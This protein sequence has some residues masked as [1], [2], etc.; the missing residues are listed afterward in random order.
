[1]KLKEIK[2][3]FKVNDIS[4]YDSYISSEVLK[5]A[6]KLTLIKDFMDF[7]KTNNIKSIFM[8][9]KFIDIDE[10]LIDPSYMKSIIEL[11]SEKLQSAIMNDV[12]KFNEKI[13]K[14]DFSDPRKITLLASYQGNYIYYEYNNNFHID[15][16]D[17][18]E[19]CRNAGDV[20]DNHEENMLCEEEFIQEKVDEQKVKLENILLQDT[21]F[22]ACKDV[23]SRYKY[24]KYLLENK[25]GSDYYELKT[26]WAID[27]ILDKSDL[28]MLTFI[29]EVWKKIN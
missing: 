18:E 13:R 2:K 23:E 4:I 16:V 8:R 25:L 15:G 20:F 24:V 28:N 19:F 22:R 26:S 12:D 10:Y 21:I 7:L 6:V 3:L 1:M 9:V 14:L 11:Y 5:N 17:I 27:C 29:E